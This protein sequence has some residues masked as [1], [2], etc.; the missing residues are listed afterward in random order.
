MSLRQRTRITE[1][2]DEL[3]NV[4]ERLV[5]LQKGAE[6]NKGEKMGEDRREDGMS[7]EE[8]EEQIRDEGDSSTEYLGSFRLMEEQERNDWVSV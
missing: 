4:L 3:R 5:E 1:A 8:A 7:V 2:G 6:W